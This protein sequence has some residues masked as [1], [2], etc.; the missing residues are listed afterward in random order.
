MEYKKLVHNVQM[1][2]REKGLN[3]PKAQNGGHNG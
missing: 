1:W 2:G 3:D